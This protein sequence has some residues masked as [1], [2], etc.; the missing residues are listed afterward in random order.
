MSKKNRRGN[1]QP[2]NNT[3]DIPMSDETT[4]GAETTAG[5]ETTVGS[6]GADS[7]AGTESTIGTEST[8]GTVNLETLMG[9]QTFSAM[10]VAEMAAILG[11]TPNDYV[12]PAAISTTAPQDPDPADYVPPEAKSPEDPE[13]ADLVDEAN[14]KLE[15]FELYAKQVMQYNG[16]SRKQAWEIFCVNFA[17]MLQHISKEPDMGLVPNEQ[18]VLLESLISR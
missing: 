17:N 6:E 3:K 10:A 15:D 14:R 7:V 1:T 11:E 8:S 18:R 12:P 9:E 5:T 16:N 4:A 13:I 2:S